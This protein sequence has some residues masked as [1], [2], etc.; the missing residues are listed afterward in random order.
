MLNRFRLV[1]GLLLSLALLS[2][3]SRSPG[4]P[5][6]GQV[7]SG[8]RLIETADGQRR[9]AGLDEIT[10]ISRESHGL[11]K[12]PGYRDVTHEALRAEAAAL[13]SSR[14]DEA[15]EAEPS[16]LPPVVTSIAPQSLST[17][18]L[19]QG[20]SVRTLLPSLSAE[21]MAR[22]VRELSEFPTRNA[23]SAHGVASMELLRGRFAEA[24]AGRDDITIEKFEH[25]F[26]DSYKEMLA[27][28]VEGE[29]ACQPSLIVR[30]R[31]QGPLAN[32]KVVIGGHGDSIR[33]Q[34]AVYSRAPGAD[35]NA[36]GVATVLEIFRAIVKS[37]LRPA[38]TLEFMIYA[39]EEYGLLGSAEIAQAYQDRREAVVGVLQFDMTMH[40]GSGETLVHMTDHTD[41]RMNAFITRL[42][43]A[44]AP[45]PM[46]ESECGYGCS[47]HASWTAA[48]FPASFP[49]E[50]TFDDY[51]KTI[52][53]ADDLP[54]LLDAAFGLHFAKLGLAFALELGG[55]PAPSACMEN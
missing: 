13:S 24:A 5:A 16:P 50:S 40:A 55:E 18:P 38:R 36:S 54:E 49:F 47:D 30:I 46:R 21:S 1:G 34:T 32:E 12:C 22:T 6:S 35:D 45:L 31:G 17:R 44:Y 11:G 41:E 39:A 8:K 14:A 51:N 52:H 7:R 43:S 9:W 26:C 27:G 29:L 42:A 33:N 19:A 15:P 53:T 28:A 20:A 10:K 48:G 37:G 23:F 25:S 2:A 4:A 3:C